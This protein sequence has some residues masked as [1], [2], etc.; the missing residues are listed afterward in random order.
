[1][2]LCSDVGA[3]SVA[4]G[5]SVLVSNVFLDNKAGSYGGAIAYQDQCFTVYDT[6]GM[7]KASH[8]AFGGEHSELC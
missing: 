3:V 5:V 6:T 2:T 4:G 7:Y 8:C 1:M